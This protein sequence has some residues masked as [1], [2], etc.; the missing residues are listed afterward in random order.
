MREILFRGKRLDNGGWVTGGTIIHFL[1]D[2]IH[3]VFMPDMNGKCTTLHE[4]ETGNITSLEDCLMYKVDPE[5]VGQFTGLNDRNGKPIFEGDIAEHVY[6]AYP[7]RCVSRG[8]V[9]YDEEHARFAHMLQSMNP[10]LGRITTEAWEVI[11]NIH[12]NPELMEVRA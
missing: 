10:E 8:I 3:T 4:G 11:G 12:D 5:T 6:Q 1:D 2:G 7:R 9:F